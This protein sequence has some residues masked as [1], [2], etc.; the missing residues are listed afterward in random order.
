MRRLDYDFHFS[1]FRAAGYDPMVREP[2]RIWSLSDAYR[3]LYLYE[4]A[5]RERVVQEHDA[6][7]AA[8][9]RHDL[10]EVVEHVDRHRAKVPVQLAAVIEGDGTAANRG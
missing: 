6:I 2:R 7:I 10:D 4:P 1:I 3:S 9:R 8:L 5:G